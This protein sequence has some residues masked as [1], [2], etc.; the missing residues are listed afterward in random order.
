MKPFVIA[1]SGGS[2]SGKTT[3]AR[4]VR[5]RLGPERCAY[6]C[7]DS[8]FHDLSEQFAKD[9]RSVNFDHP[10]SIDFDLLACQLESLCNGKTVRIPIYD[11]VTHTRSEDT[12]TIEPRPVILVEGILLLTLPRI[13][14]LADRTVFVEAPESLRYQRRLDRDIRER[15]RTPDGVFTQFSEQVAPMHNQ[16]VEPSKI[17]ADLVCNGHHVADWVD[18]I[19]GWV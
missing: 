14:A 15:G 18:T 1:I 11:F 16:Y 7:Q 13:R 8:Y 19:C 10:S 17:F 12:R 9:S 5:E 2:G 4:L 6:L 3:L